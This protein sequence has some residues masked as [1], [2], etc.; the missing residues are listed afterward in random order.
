MAFVSLPDV[1]AACRDVEY[2]LDELKLDGINLQTH[3]A[4]RYLGHS[5]E[6]E[7]YAELNRRGAVVFVHPQRPPLQGLSKFAFPAGYTELVFDTT[8][9]IANLLYTGTLSKY[10]RIRFIMPHMGG[11]TPFLLFRLSGFDDDPKLR[12]KI[13][14]GVAAQLKRLYYDVAQSAAPLALRALL[15]IAD[16]S[17]I[18]FGTD[19]PSAL[20][21][22]KVMRDTIQ[23]VLKFDGFDEATRRK[24]MSENA[25]AIL[26]RFSQLGPS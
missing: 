11:V 16:P 22:E 17:R 12:E 20:N 1:E 7:L 4:Q 19:Y 8:R 5:E 18:L 21:A 26:P 15:E 10:P 24:V 13:P 9:A 14:D 2:A 6:N 23:E 25:R 3:T